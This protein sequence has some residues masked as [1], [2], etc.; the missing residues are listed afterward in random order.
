M[1]VCLSFLSPSAFI[2]AIAIPKSFTDFAPEIT[3]DTSFVSSSS[4]AII[5]STAFLVLKVSSGLNSVLV[6]NRFKNH[7][8]F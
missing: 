7:L 4:K 5:L 2:L 6:V 1:D 3:P 8:L